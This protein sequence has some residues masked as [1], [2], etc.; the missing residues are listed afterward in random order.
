MAE[1]Q[2]VLNHH[3]SPCC[4]SCR[5]LSVNANGFGKYQDHKVQGNNRTKKR[6]EG[7]VILYRLL[8]AMSTKCNNE[9]VCRCAHYANSVLA[10]NNKFDG[11]PDCL[12]N[13]QRISRK[14]N[15]LPAEEM[16]VVCVLAQIVNVQVT[17]V[18]FRYVS[19]VK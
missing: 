13:R 4:K 7:F 5:H 6:D 2:A 9:D 12:Q 16:F 3:G 19:W 8:K 18:A 10:K 1:V 11:L 15:E 14:P 17:N